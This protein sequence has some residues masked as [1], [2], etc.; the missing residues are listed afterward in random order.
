M[1]SRERRHYHCCGGI[2]LC[3]ETRKRRKIIGEHRTG[4]DRLQLRLRCA[5]PA[6]PAAHRG[7]SAAIILSTCYSCIAKTVRATVIQYGQEVD[8]EHPI[9]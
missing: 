8:Y 9:T 6:L 1:V 3:N 7:C 2:G 4:A 5:L